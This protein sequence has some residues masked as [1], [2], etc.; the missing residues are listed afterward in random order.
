MNDRIS[1]CGGWRA[2]RYALSSAHEGVRACGTVCLMSLMTTTLTLL[3]LLY[4]DTWSLHTLVVSRD[5][6]PSTCPIINVLHYGA[7]ERYRPHP[8]ILPPPTNH[9]IHPISST[10]SQSSP[11]HLLSLF[12][13]FLMI[14]RPP[15]STLFPYTT[16]FR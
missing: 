1:V 9:Y 16:L 11:P 6:H 15:R 13:F 8:D 14:R 2:R 10:A 4:T 5:S 7:P 3:R 12:F